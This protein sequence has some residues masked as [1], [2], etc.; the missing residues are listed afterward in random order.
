VRSDTL[1]KQELSKREAEDKVAYLLKQLR[2]AETKISRLETLAARG[3]SKQRESFSSVFTAS[4]LTS[5]NEGS[6]PLIRSTSTGSGITPS[7]IARFDDKALASCIHTSSSRTYS[8]VPAPITAL[9]EPDDHSSSTSSPTLSPRNQTPSLV[10]PRMMLRP[11]SAHNLLPDPVD[12]TAGVRTSL[13]NKY[14]LFVNSSKPGDGESGSSEV[15]D[16]VVKR[17]ATEKDK[18][19]KN[20]K[21]DK[22]DEDLLRELNLLKNQMKSPAP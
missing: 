6:V 5:K 19:D 3:E 8:N 2:S 16:E 13:T 10:G 18:K 4:D 22:K 12:N 7:V 17:W 15:Q 20:E 21:S 1:K 14:A 9:L 11:V